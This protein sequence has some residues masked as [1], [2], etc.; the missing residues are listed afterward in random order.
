MFKRRPCFN[1]TL[2]TDLKLE[3]VHRKASCEQCCYFYTNDLKEYN[4]NVGIAFLVLH[5][6]V[7][8]NVF[9]YWNMRIK[10]QINYL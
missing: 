7:Y 9:R 6:I 1:R 4:N 5:N 8:A 2:Y 3:F 10:D